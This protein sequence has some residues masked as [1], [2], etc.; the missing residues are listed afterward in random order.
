MDD[1]VL[2]LRKDFDALTQQIKLSKCDNI[3]DALNRADLH[4]KRLE[5]MRRIEQATKQRGKH[6]KI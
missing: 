3:D 5:I 4:R 6:F 2:K 1:V